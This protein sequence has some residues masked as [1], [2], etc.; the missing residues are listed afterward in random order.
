MIL[1]F[2]ITNHKTQ[3][4]SDICISFNKNYCSKHGYDFLELSSYV[5]NGYHYTW[6]KIFQSIDL[7]KSKEYNY[8]FLDADAMIINQNIKLESIIDR[9]NYDI[10][11]SENGS[12]GPKMVATGAFLFNKKALPL[13]ELCLELSKTT[14]S[15]YKNDYWFEMTIIDEIYKQGLFNIDLF[16]MNT[17]NST[18]F[19]DHSHPLL[20]SLFVYH[21]QGRSDEAKTKIANELYH[22][23]NKESI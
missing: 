18:V 5:P 19:T 23:Y 17:M 21:F 1:F 8:F 3:P 2:Q 9:M 15:K 11:F 4:Y 12:N 14:M 7:L 22:R 16:D 20:D 6:S 10:S 13:F